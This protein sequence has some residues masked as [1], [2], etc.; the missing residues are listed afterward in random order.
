MYIWCEKCAS[1]YKEIFAPFLLSPRSPSL[2]AR[3]LKTKQIRIS[4][5]ISFKN[6]TVSGRI[7]DGAKP[8]EVKKD[9][10]NPL[11][12]KFGENWFSTS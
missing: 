1:V 4:Q 2:S 12:I 9:E 11:Y 3:E 7:Q 6:T 10:N 8:F 5:I